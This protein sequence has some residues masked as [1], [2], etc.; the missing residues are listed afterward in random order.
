MEKH[1]H[2]LLETPNISTF[3]GVIKRRMRKMG[4][5][6]PLDFMFAQMD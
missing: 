4:E 5:I 2:H 3:I 1:F 6:G